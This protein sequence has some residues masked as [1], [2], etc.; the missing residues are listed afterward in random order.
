MSL[1]I[2]EE[3]ADKE[4]IRIN[5]LRNMER[6]LMIIA[7]DLNFSPLLFKSREYSKRQKWENIRV[8]CYSYEYG[9]RDKADLIYQRGNEKWEKE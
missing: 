8:S 7:Q 4:L 3:F 1:K 6:L 2:K 5:N 9:F